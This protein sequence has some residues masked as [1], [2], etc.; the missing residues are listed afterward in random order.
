MPQ[1]LDLL[2]GEVDLCPHDDVLPALLQRDAFFIS[3]RRSQDFR[4][5]TQWH[6]AKAH[7]STDVEAG[8]RLIEV[9]LE[10]ECRLKQFAAAEQEEHSKQ[11]RETDHYEPT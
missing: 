10:G 9:S 2:R 8:D 6:A 11:N 5:L 1:L 4:D 3:G 7:W